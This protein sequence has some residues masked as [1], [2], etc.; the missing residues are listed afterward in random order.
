M[1]PNYLLFFLIV[2]GCQTKSEVTTLPYHAISTSSEAL[3]NSIITQACFTIADDLRQLYSYS[4]VGLPQ[5][6]HVG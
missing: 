1:K 2:K 6:T 4:G 3:I 5:R